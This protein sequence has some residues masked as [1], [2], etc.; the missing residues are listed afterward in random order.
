MQSYC[1]RPVCF[2]EG[3]AMESEAVL[4]TCPYSVWFI[5]PLQAPEGTQQADLAE[6]VGLLER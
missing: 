6:E 1:V 2:F 3:H 5:L 4:V